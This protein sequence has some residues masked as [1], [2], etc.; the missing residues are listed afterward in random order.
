MTEE[1][2]NE[3]SDSNNTEEGRQQQEQKQNENRNEQEAVPPLLACFFRDQE[4]AEHAYHSLRTRG[5]RDNEIDIL[6]SKETRD[7]H[8][9]D[10]EAVTTTTESRALEGAGAGTAIGGTLGAIV[11]GVAAVAFPGIGLVAAGPVAAVFAGGGAGA[12]AGGIT[13]ALVGWGLPEEHAEIYESGI[14]EG[15]TVIGIR[16]KSLEDAEH[17]E[18]LW[19][20]E[21]GGKHIHR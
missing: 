21:Y 4:K 6:M 2:N 12:L 20:E 17:L 1:A 8:W 15:G 9:G 10:R 19:A 13:G 11:A 7:E 5:Y 3:M 18:R 14:E 16:P